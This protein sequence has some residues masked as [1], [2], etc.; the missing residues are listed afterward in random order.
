MNDP[1]LLFTELSDITPSIVVDML[2]EEY[3]NLTGSIE[4]SNDDICTI[5]CNEH[6][7]IFKASDCDAF[8]NPTTWFKMVQENLGI[9]EPGLTAAHFFLKRILKRPVKYFDIGSCFGYYSVLASEVF[10]DADV[11]AV[12]ANPTVSQALETIVSHYNINVINSCLARTSGTR[13]FL[14]R[15]WTVSNK[16][17]KQVYLQ[18]LIYSMNLMRNFWRALRGLNYLNP[19]IS[20]V[21]LCELSLTELLSIHDN[22]QNQIIFKFDTEGFHWLFLDGHYKKLADAKAIIL[23]EQ[24]SFLHMKLRG[25]SNK[26][27]FHFLRDA[28][29]ECFW[30]DHRKPKYFEHMK[31]FRRRHN[32]NSLL[33]CIPSIF[34]KM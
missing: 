34:F 18:N 8:I 1:G 3:K 14:L 6:R 7:L 33:I 20:S 19:R 21:T 17:A 27:V 26:A 28:G 11:V 13:E 15:G 23:L 9:H 29:Y 24:D 16:S 4:F 12:E 31:V 32:R 2:T 5:K 25:G 22:I 10:N 30:C